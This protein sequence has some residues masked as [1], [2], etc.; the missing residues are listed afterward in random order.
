MARQT[1]NAV[2]Q[3]LRTQLPSRRLGRTGLMVPALSLGGFPLGSEEINDD[4]ALETIDYALSQGINFF[5][6]APVYGESERRLGIALSRAPRDTFS[7]S[8]KTG[9]LSQLPADYSW[10]G[11]MRSVENSLRLLKTDYLDIVHV[12]DPGWHS[13]EGMKTI[14]ESRGTLDAL[15][16]LKVQRVVRNIGLGEKRFDFHKAAIE[17]GRFDVILCFNNYHP[18]DVSAADWLFTLA[19]SRDVG[20]MI[21]SPMAHGLLNG[22]VPENY[23][24]DQKPASLWPLLPDARKLY[25]WCRDNKVSM[26]AVVLQFCLRQPLIDITLTGVKSRAKLEQNL[27]AIT[28]PLPE[29]TWDALSEL[30]ITTSRYHGQIPAAKEVHP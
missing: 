25:D 6:T 14:M 7:I 12:H 17:S 27:N 18:L 22:Q 21:G 4:L 5:D 24:V 15:E 3:R 1:T 10:D 8:T 11:T 30:G 9:T 26:P 28:T 23:F 13:P 20:V 16:H 19:K 2:T 29:E